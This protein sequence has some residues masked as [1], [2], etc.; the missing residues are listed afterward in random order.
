MVR[1]CETRTAVYPRKGSAL[2]FYSMDPFG[3]LDSLS[4][5][6]GCPVL[7]GQKWAANVWVWNKNAGFVDEECNDKEMLHFEIENMLG[8]IAEHEIFP[9]VDSVRPLT[10]I[11]SAFDQIRDFKQ[12]G[13][14][15]IEIQ[16][17]SSKR[18]FW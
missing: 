16:L 17:D 8:F 2:L 1:E 13:K 15:V 6:G 10:E 11:V 5:H 18:K 4:N 3:R 7:V 12:L 9:I 14:L